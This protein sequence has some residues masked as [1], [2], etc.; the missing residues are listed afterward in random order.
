MPV[1]EFLIFCRSQHRRIALLAGLELISSLTFIAL[2]LTLSRLLSRLLP[3]TPPLPASDI[4]DAAA[5]DFLVLLVVLFTRAIIV[6][7]HRHILSQLACQLGL[8]LRHGLHA[9]L[10]ATPT[11]SRPELPSLAIESV[12]A[13]GS[14]AES[15]LPVLLSLAVNTPVLLAAAAVLDPL[16]SLLMLLSLPIAPVFL[17]L[18]GQLTKSGTEKQL[19]ELASLTAGF[20]ELLQGLTTLK[21]FGQEKAQRQLLTTLSRRF[22]DASLKVLRLAFLSSFAIELITTLSIAII[23]VLIGFRL[24]SGSLTFAS[25]FAILLLAPAF[26]APLRRS[27]QAFHTGMTAIT[28]WQA[29]RQAAPASAPAPRGQEAELALP[30]GLSVRGLCYR[31]PG[32][33]EDILQNLSF[34]CPAGSTLAL[35]GPSGSGKSTLLRLLAGLDSPVAGTIELV[36]ALPPTAATAAEHPRLIAHQPVSRLAPA[37]RARLIAYVPQE[38]H[39]FSA[40]L[41]ENL[42]LFTA[43]IATA[44]GSYPEHDPDTI[45]AARL[46]QSLR[47]AG[48]ADW[49][50]RLP[51]GLDTRLGEGAQPLSNGERHRLGLARAILR[52]PSL[53]L[54]DEPTAGLDAASEAA[55]IHSLTVL[56]RR[57]TIIVATH[58]SALAAWAD[59]RLTLA[60]GPA[61]SLST[62][63]PNAGTTSPGGAPC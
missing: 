62:A 51:A 33:G 10:S 50:D 18:I 28:A 29:V 48:L 19:A 30:P 26:Y 63:A 5:P 38:P 2:A 49:Y 9:G 20:Q 12:D 32:T 46:E 22:A 56:S 52:S 14:L 53:L 61:G 25:A 15:V 36:S 21:L 16:S 47:L 37:S 27:G 42:T 35:L 11:A 31:Y 43:T 39:I 41:A 34:T 54:L 44:A 7:P 1:K 60:P 6:W 4:W 3:V 55:I 57:R 45:P 23:A 58:R 59:Q 17:A 40:S 8:Q 24:L 13:A